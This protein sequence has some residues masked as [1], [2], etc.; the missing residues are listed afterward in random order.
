MREE[1]A[2]DDASVVYL[3]YMTEIALFKFPNPSGDNLISDHDRCCGRQ[4]ARAPDF[5][6]PGLL[7]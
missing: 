5:G 6:T 3:N 1:D 4:H 2:Q 7:R